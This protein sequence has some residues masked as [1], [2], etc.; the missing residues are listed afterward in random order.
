MLTL[1]QVPQLLKEAVANA[2]EPPPEAASLDSL[3]REFRRGAA[4]RDSLLG[5]ATLWFSGVLWLAL[6]APMPWLGW[7]QLSAAIAL[8]LWTRFAAQRQ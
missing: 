7:V 2:Q 6:G 8:L 4:Q 5:A 3:R 1:R